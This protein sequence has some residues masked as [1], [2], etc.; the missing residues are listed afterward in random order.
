MPKHKKR[1]SG[2]RTLLCSYQSHLFD[3]STDP[4]YPLQEASEQSK[5]SWYCNVLST[6]VEMF[7]TGINHQQTPTSERPA[8]YGN[9]ESESERSPQRKLILRKAVFAAHTRAARRYWYWSRS[10]RTRL[11][12]PQAH[13]RHIRCCPSCSRRQVIDLYS[14]EQRLSEA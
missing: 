13:G 12:V 2:S 8:A 5:I 4:N 14:R 3:K 10:T 7:C 1:S 9:E 6:G 11:R